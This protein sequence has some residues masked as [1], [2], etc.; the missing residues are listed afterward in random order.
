MRACNVDVCTHDRQGRVHQE[1]PTWAATVVAGR[2]SEASWIASDLDDTA[3]GLKFSNGP[4]LAVSTPA[5]KRY[6]K[7]LQSCH[8]I[9]VYFPNGSTIVIKEPGDMYTESDEKK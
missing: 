8:D 9:L 4:L 5:K 7:A 3:N 1:I 2:N 6:M